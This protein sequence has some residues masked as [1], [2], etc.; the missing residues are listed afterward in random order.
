V[1]RSAAHLPHSSSSSAAVGCPQA[2]A[3]PVCTLSQPPRNDVAHQDENGIPP[4]RPLRWVRRGVVVDVL[5]HCRL[6]MRG[7]LSVDLPA[8]A[9]SNVPASAAPARRPLRRRHVLEFR[10]GWGARDST[11]STSC[12]VRASSGRR[13][14]L[15]GVGAV[16]R[17]SIPAP[18]GKCSGQGRGNGPIGA[19]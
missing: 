10:N 13:R 7:I 19:N 6:R 8:L 3:L 18:G 5:H 17:R 2:D 15:V 11:L 1:T 14:D 16:D 9:G 4:D 12:E